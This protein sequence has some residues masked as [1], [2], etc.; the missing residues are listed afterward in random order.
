M[1]ANQVSASAGRSIYTVSQLNR[2]IRQLLESEMGNIWL[3]GE[4]S[5]F[6]CPSSGHWYFSLKDSKAQIRCAMFKG[7]NRSVRLQPKD[8][9]QVLVRARLSLYEPRGDYQLIV[10]LMEDAG[11]GLL[12]QKFDA[13][14]AKLDS[15][16]LFAHTLKKPI[17]R[18]PKRIGII[19]SATGAAVKDILTVLKRRSPATEIIIYP[20]LVQGEEATMSLVG[21]LAMAN[22]RKEVDTLIIGRGGGSLEDLW[23][24]NEEALALAIAASELPV[25]SAVGH[26][27]DTSISDLVADLRAPTPSAAAELVCSD[28]QVQ[29]QQVQQLA[30]RLSK[31]ASLKLHQGKQKLVWITQRLTQQDP[32]QQLQRQSQRLDELQHRLV[33]AKLNRLNRY[34]HRLQSSGLKIRALAPN[35]QMNQ[36]HIS[37]LNTRLIQAMEQKL[38]QGQQALARQA[39]SLDMISPLAV[40]GRG[41]SIAKKS[42]GEVIKHAEQVQ[43]GDKIQIQLAED[44]LNAQI[45]ET[46]PKQADL[47]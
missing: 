30:S 24:F 43:V 28:Q 44:S 10:E 32:K 46:N 38:Q 31:A 21:A 12:K 4:I 18:S 40:L 26:E 42:N 33:Q 7:N 13:L 36:Q 16:G 2:Q 34:K 3:S 39:A 20:S 29:Q 45:I 8:G 11:E 27:V 35:I 19:T 22:R 23:C 37:H 47:F 9:S 15:Q 6:M 14:K 1:L 25:I 5:N 41:Y 17:P